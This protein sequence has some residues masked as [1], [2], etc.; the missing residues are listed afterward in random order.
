MSLEEI[1]NEFETDTVSDLD[2][3]INFTRQQLTDFF[4]SKAPEKVEAY[5]IQKDGQPAIEAM[6]QAGAFNEAID[7]YINNIRKET[8]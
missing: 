2:A 7:A 6:M 5:K 4:V 3:K 8:L 1:L